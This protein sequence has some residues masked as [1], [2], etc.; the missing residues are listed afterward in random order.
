MFDNGAQSSP[1]AA[2]SE[3]F[4][5]DF[6]AVSQIVG[7]LQ[8][9]DPAGRVRIL[10]TVATFFRLDAA[11][12]LPRR[13]GVSA[14]LLQSAPGSSPLASFSEDRTP[15]SKDFIRDKRPQTDVERIACLAY[16]LTHYRDTPH[17]KTV[18]LSKLNTDAAQIK[19]SN[20]AYAVENASKAGFLVAAVKGTKQL[21]AFGEEYVQALPDRAAAKQ[22]MSQRRPRRK[23]KRNSA[24]GAKN[25]NDGDDDSGS[26]DTD[27][28]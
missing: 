13:E 8:R 7:A 20:A 4:A 25:G 10:R 24:P 18:D 2:S 21:S 23:T 1:D 27:H 26:A 28:G 15:S 12:V 17:F 14:Q 6:D 11:E 22:V 9:F 16:Y 3:D 5:S 19:F